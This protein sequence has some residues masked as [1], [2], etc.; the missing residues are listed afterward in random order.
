MSK[1]NRVFYFFLIILTIGLGLFSRTEYIPAL[2]YPYLGD[3][4]YA[5]MFYFLIGFLLPRLSSLSV[6][7]ISLGFCF[8]IEITQLYQA[9]WINVIRQTRIGSL[10]LGHGFLWSDLLAYIAG[11]LVG[12][13]LELKIFSRVAYK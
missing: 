4:L 6:F 3:L 5:T 7:L 11:S 8:F 1:R 9:D 2:I 10:V 13:V 12:F